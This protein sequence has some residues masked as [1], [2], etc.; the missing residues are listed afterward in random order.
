MSFTPD[1]DGMRLHVADLDS[2]ASK[3]D[4]EDT[5]IK[6]GPLEEIWMARSVPCFAF[7]VHKN[8]EDAYEDRRQIEEDRIKIEEPRRRITELTYHLNMYLQFKPIIEFILI[9]CE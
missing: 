3:W 7:V 9:L 8:K 4:I 2:I 6:F 1:M 5:F